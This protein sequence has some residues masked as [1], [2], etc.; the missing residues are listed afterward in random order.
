[1]C[2]CVS[3]EAEQEHY[4][5]WAAGKAATNR[6]QMVIHLYKW[7]YFVWARVHFGCQFTC[8]SNEGILTAP[9][10]PPLILPSRQD[11]HGLR[12]KVPSLK[13]RIELVRGEANLLSLKY[14]IWS[15]L[16]KTPCNHIQYKSLPIA[17]GW[18]DSEWG[19]VIFKDTFPPPFFPQVWHI[20]VLKPCKT[21]EI[22]EIDDIPKLR[23]SCIVRAYEALDTE[24]LAWSWWR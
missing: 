24:A 9:K 16:A 19:N 11:L 15:V 5:H 1:M 2:F 20:A 18:S 22:F 10:L 23:S 21:M 4:P 14:L 8:C 6:L 7:I 17:F 13:V 12:W 3:W